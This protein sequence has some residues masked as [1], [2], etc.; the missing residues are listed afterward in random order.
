M[1]HPADKR[2]SRSPVLKF[3][4]FTNANA[5]KRRASAEKCWWGRRT[6]INFTWL[7]HLDEGDKA[8]LKKKKS[9]CTPSSYLLPF[10]EVTL[11]A[12][13]DVSY[14]SPARGI[15]T[16]DRGTH[17]MF[18]LED[19]KTAFSSFFGSWSNSPSQKGTTHPTTCTLLTF[20]LIPTKDSHV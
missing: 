9:G 5:E 7:S 2:W 19:N 4:S 10:N 6:Q 18:Q 14:K 8:I 16:T 1:L 3:Q 12:L 17:G 13:R 11:H 15:H 20:Y